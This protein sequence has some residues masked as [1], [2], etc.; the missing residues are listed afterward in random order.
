MKRTKRPCDTVAN[1]SSLATRK[2]DVR[3]LGTERW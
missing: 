2:A 3:D 1:G